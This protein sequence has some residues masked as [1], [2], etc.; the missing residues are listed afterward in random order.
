MLISILTY[1]LCETKKGAWFNLSSRGTVPA[2]MVPRNIFDEER[3]GCNILTSK[4]SVLMVVV[5]I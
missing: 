4:W 1:I 3:V 5:D 2:T